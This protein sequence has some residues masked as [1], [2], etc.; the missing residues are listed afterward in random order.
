MVLIGFISED[1]F[2]FNQLS[3]WDNIPLSNSAGPNGEEVSSLSNSIGLNGG[4]GLF[5]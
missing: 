5:L 1:L 4:E 3:K 2:Q